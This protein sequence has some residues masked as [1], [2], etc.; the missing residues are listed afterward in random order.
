MIRQA[1][2]EDYIM[3]SYM[4]FMGSQR[5]VK[6]R[7]L[8]CAGHVTRMGNERGAW[9]LLVGKP[10]G[11]RPVGR[12]RMRWENNVNHDLREVDNT[13]DD[14]KTLAEDRD[15]WRAYVHAVMNLRVR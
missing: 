9:K 14:W 5:I 13:G 1:N 7:R 10:E 15:V 8:R 4:I 6:S 3:V 2:G 12:P 11:K